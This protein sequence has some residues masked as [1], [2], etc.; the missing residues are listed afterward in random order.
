M[1]MQFL[2]TILKPII[3]KQK[4]QR[5]FERMHKLSL[6]GMNIGTGGI[7]DGSGEK[8]VLEYIK[9]KFGDN[10]KIIHIFDVGANEGYYSILLG[11]VFEFNVQIYSFEPSKKTFNELLKNTQHYE[12]IRHFNFG[13][14]E[15]AETLNLYS[16]P[17]VSTLS[18]LYQRK[19]DHFGIQMNVLEK[20]EISTI[21]TFCAE[22]G[23]NH[24]HFLK[25][26]IEGHELSA[27]KGAYNMML[28]GKI[29]FIQF[30][31]G[32]CNIDSKTFFQDFFYLLIDNYNI[33]R[34]LQDGLSKIEQYSELNDIF[35][36]TNFLAEK[37]VKI[38]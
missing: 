12:N 27:L 21:D 6:E 2:R 38:I 22:L 37:K 26:D 20:V 28:A 13:F 31:F 1:K 34:I 32:G 33:Y 23:I 17:E 29:D 3:G 35:L 7:A 30:E 9:N 15:K 16:Y 25:L 18:S 19:L 4:Y 24:I 8:L 36:T 14:G 5:L 10:Q 11:T